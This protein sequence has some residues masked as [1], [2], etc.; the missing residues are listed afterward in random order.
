MMVR[1]RTRRRSTCAVSGR[2]FGQ[3]FTAREFVLLAF[4]WP[5]RSMTAHPIGTYSCLSARINK[6]SC[7]QYAGNTPWK[8][9]QMSQALQNI[10]L[11]PSQLIGRRVLRQATLPST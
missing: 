8:L 6:A 7:G 3:N 9:I 10:G 5:S 4:E 1:L 2:K 11:L